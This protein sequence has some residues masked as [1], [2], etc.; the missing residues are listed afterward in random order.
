MPIFRVIKCE[1]IKNENDIEKVLSNFDN[2]N[3]LETN[4]KSEAQL[5]HLKKLTERIKDFY[6]D[7]RRVSLGNTEKMEYRIEINIPGTDETTW[8]DSRRSSIYFPFPSIVILEQPTTVF[9]RL[10]KL[11]LEH[12]LMKPPKS[13]YISKS[14]IDVINALKNTHTAKIADISVY[15]VILNRIRFNSKIFEEFNIKQPDLDEEF[16]EELDNQSRSWKAF[17]FRISIESEVGNSFSLRID[18]HGG[19][20]LYGK[21]F[22]SRAIFVKKLL[23]EIVKNLF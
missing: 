3:K 15:R 8:I 12:T 18:R 21:Y 17:T 6:I 14:L 4:I 5:N 22:E 19:A 11:S 7:N 20:L 16:I 23:A 9:E 2:W 1:N 13:P 10:F